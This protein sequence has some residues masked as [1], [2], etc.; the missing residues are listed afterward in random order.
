LKE[1]IKDLGLKSK[2]EERDYNK[3]MG[4]DLENSE[5]K[6]PFYQQF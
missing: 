3:K 1:A 2:A 6:K 5:N 4:K